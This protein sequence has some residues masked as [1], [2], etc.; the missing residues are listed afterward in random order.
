MP[1][2]LLLEQLNTK[3]SQCDR[4][5]ELFKRG[6]TIT[7]L[8]ATIHYGITQLGARLTELEEK[9]YVFN[10][11]W[12]T[13]PSGTRVKEYSLVIAE[14]RGDQR[15]SGGNLIA[16]NGADGLACGGQANLGD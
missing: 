9:G 13:L 4:L 5:L 10:K 16:V 11:V 6:G 12:K 2:Q 1:E 8:E 15:S 3:K 7:S 14:K